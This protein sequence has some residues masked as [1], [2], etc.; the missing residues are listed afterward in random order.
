MKLNNNIIYISK[1]QYLLYLIKTLPLN[2]LKFIWKWHIVLIPNCIAIGGNNKENNILINLETAF[3][4]M[5]KAKKNIK[6]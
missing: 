2:L 3:E 4:Y 5:G 1:K 6:Q